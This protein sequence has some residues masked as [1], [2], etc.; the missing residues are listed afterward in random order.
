MFTKKTSVSESVVQAETL[1][2]LQGES[3]AHE[4]FIK[5]SIEDLKSTNKQAAAEK[6]KKRQKS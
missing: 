6:E 4:E 2:N 5:Q 1:A 3:A